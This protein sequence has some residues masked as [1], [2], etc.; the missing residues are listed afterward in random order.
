M[1]MLETSPT[2][3]TVLDWVE[4]RPAL[5]SEKGDTNQDVTLFVSRLAPR[6]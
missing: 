1:A 6:R 4:S 5:K 3:Q 2:A